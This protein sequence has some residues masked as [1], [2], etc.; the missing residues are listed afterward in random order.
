MVKCNP[1]LKL[2]GKRPPGALRLHRK[3]PTPM[4]ANIMN[5]CAMHGTLA[6]RYEFL[7][8]SDLTE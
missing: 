8:M 3:L 4:S 7:N 5:V 2:L 6:N 1:K